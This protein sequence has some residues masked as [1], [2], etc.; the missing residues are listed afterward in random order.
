M[1][2]DE[3]HAAQ[4]IEGIRAEYQLVRESLEIGCVGSALSSLERLQEQAEALYESHLSLVRQQLLV[5]EPLLRR[6]D[7]TLAH[8]RTVGPRPTR[9]SEAT[10]EQEN[11][12][13]S[14]G[15]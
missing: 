3:W 4:L 1:S 9:R 12:G 11:L 8:L 15:G 2:Y 13:G 7:Q 14:G 5:L 6:L 10:E